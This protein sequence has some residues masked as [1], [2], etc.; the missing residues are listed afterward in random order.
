ML[1]LLLLLLV[2]VLRWTILHACCIPLVLPFSSVLL[3]YSFRTRPDSIP[4]AP[5]A[6]PWLT[7]AG[8]RGGTQDFFK[9]VKGEERMVRVGLGLVVRRTCSR[10]NSG[11]CAA[12]FGARDSTWIQVSPTVFSPEYG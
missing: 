3:C 1:L 4:P 10:W 12:A 2:T 9:E 11:S 6:Q 8:R 5:P 7:E